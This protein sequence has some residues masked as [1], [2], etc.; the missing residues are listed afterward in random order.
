MNTRSHHNIGEHKR[1]KYAIRK[2]NVGIAS[3]LFGA[4]VLL[5]MAHDTKAAEIPTLSEQQSSQESTE[6]ISNENI[7]TTTT[8]TTTSTETTE[9]TTSDVVSESAS[10]SSNEVHTTETPSEESVNVTQADTTTDTETDAI[11]PESGAVNEEAGPEAVQSII[12]EKK[13]VAS[14]E[15]QTVESTESSQKETKDL[16]NQ[17]E[18]TPPKSDESQPVN[19]RTQHTQPQTNSGFRAATDAVA[20]PN[21]P[22]PEAQTKP[23][24]VDG[25]NEQVYQKEIPVLAGSREAQTLGMQRG[26]RQG[27]ES[28][29]IILPENTNLYIRQS[30][31]QNEAD[32][33]VSLMTN[34]G[35]YNKSATIPKSGEWVSVST[36]I[37][38]AAFVYL[39]RGLNQ[40]PLVDFYVENNQMKA[41]PTYRRGQNQEAFE[42][43]WVDQ[44]SSYAFVDGT[45][46]AF[47]IP[48]VDRD[49]VLNMK[50][51]QDPQALHNLDEMI[52]Y[53]D[54]VIK[55]Y[56]QW[57][58]LNDD[59]TSVNFNLGQKYFTT[60]NK[61]GYGLA[62][63]SWDHMGSN[64][65]SMYGYLTKGWIALHE[66]GHGYDGHLISDPK[67]PLAEV[68]NNIFANEYQMNVENKDRGWLYK[69]DQTGFQKNMQDNVLDPQI[70]DKF[71]QY[72]VEERLDFMTRMVR[73]TSI[74]GVT[75]M[76][77]KVREKASEGLLMT[78]VPAWIGKY[79]LADRGYNG[80]AYFDLFNLDTPQYLEDRLNTYNN[81][82]IY[83]LA[84][85]IEN[86]AERQKYVEKLGLATAY[87]LVKSTDLADTT[88]TAPATVNLN[89]NGQQLANGAVVELV[90]GTTKVAQ[91][92]VENGVAVFDN[93]R[94]GVYKVVAPLS[95]TLALP[96]YAYLI[97]RENRKNEVTLD[98]PKIDAPHTALSQ[99]ISLIGLSDREFASVT[100]D[101]STKAVTYLQRK[102]QPH[103]FF[104][105]EYVHVTIEK[106][107][108]TVVYD[109]SFVGNAE[110]A[111]L[112]QT[113]QMDYGD[114]ITVMH[115]EP[116]RRFIRR[117]ETEALMT[118]P[119]ASDKT[120]TYVLTEQGLM[121]E[122]ETPTDVAARY[123]E[124]MQND[125]NALIQNME[126][127]PEKDYRTQLYRLVQGVNEVASPDKEAL[128]AQLEPYLDQQTTTPL[129]VNP[130]EYDNQTISGQTSNDARVEVTLPSGQVLTTTADS[131]G[132]W[133]MTVPE[134]NRLAWQDTVQVTAYKNGEITSQTVSA[135]VVDTIRPETPTITPTQAG[136]RIVKGTAVPNHQVEVSFEDGTKVTTVS[137]SDGTWSVNVPDHINLFYQYQLVA[138]T[139][140]EAGNDSYI[141]ISNVIDTIRPTQP[142]VTDTEAGSHIVWG[143]GETYKDRILVRLPGNQ[144][145]T[146][147]VGRNGT[148]MIGVPWDINLKPGDQIYAYEVDAAGN[149]SVAGIGNVVDTKAPVKPFV[150]PITSDSSVVTGQAE[151]GSTVKV[152]FP[153]N[154][155]REVQADTTGKYTVNVPLDLT[156]GETITVQAIDASNNA[157]EI[158]TVTVTDVTAP[159]A[160]TV[161][162]V[163]SD[164][165]SVTGTG[166]PGSTV[167]I[168]FPDGTTA[169]GTVGANGSYEVAIPSGV[170]LNGGEGLQVTTTDVA[171]NASPSTSTTVVDTTAP[172]AP[173]VNE[174]T[175]DATSVTGT[176]EPGSTV[177]ITFPDGTTATGTVGANGSYEVA[178]PS[179]VDLNGGEG[180]QV[181]TTDVAG[182]ASPST[183]T[184]VVDT[185]APE[186]PTVN[187]VTSDATSV[188][189]TGEPGSTVTITFPDGT[190][191]TGTVGT[192]GSYEV[193]IPSGVDLNG[194]EGLQV[195]TTDV[196]GNASPSTSTT[197]VDT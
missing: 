45:Y 114:K 86:E 109:K 108:G 47:L 38:S 151:P 156:G 25:I 78:D 29:G 152:I 14:E 141:T 66:I 12:N 148:W 13:E 31:P 40:I 132:A 104:N 77:Q 164:A 162:E 180:L 9:N 71:G 22:A 117:A 10:V 122:G 46:N 129:T 55:Q 91:A 118:L 106:Q 53:Y 175:S 173:T 186:A 99:R 130:I 92:V 35:D 70:H 170:D 64:D 187:E 196:A 174:V 27:R 5:T 134:N 79:W 60:A 140:D 191:A 135:E 75:E 120:V 142:T 163:T 168:T 178:I 93:V 2:F 63:W 96:E 112:T 61:N 48:R 158:T 195:T 184:T 1:N 26:L 179:G 194:G 181:T 188:T 19:E 15:S 100:Y 128:L 67:M 44:D 83:P 185:T 103:Y 131:S 193:A 146:T 52:D 197:V 177:T 21:M 172:E 165:T 7:D 150:E 144:V 6:S 139:F 183:S 68:W 69:G 143:Y 190:T 42:T 80:L 65:E 110:Q 154:T 58:G 94:A 167:T 176:G 98:Y 101:P 84:M 171:G 72:T 33:R 20:D 111:D 115:R 123:T 105:D 51:Q 43:Q 30:R 54:N 89:L 182:N 57:I 56:N 145:V 18:P 97:V 133:S 90:D 192:N 124:T 59:P 4:T 3:V 160:P 113:F 8:E 39:P 76:L 95:T 159:E 102:G 155:I 149:Y 73:L 41:L 32:L 138:K 74:N 166:E 153:G 23:I 49:R 137:Q 107:D 81:S 126:T 161:N 136:S 24:T 189:G 116:G 119:K 16:Q 87:E 37:E 147:K 82:Y 62:Y 121:V 88:V 169:T 17:T 11:V 127:S 157:S 36:G 125:V 34:D 85:L 50:N 28:L